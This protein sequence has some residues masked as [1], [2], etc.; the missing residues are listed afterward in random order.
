MA[1]NIIDFKTALLKGGARPN[2]FRVTLEFPTAVLGSVGIDSNTAKERSTFLVKAAQIPSSNLG[3]IEIP[4]KGRMLKVAGDR[5]FDPW[6]VTVI[7]DGDFS[8]RKLFED[9]SRQINAL[10]ENVSSLGYTSSN[11]SLAYC[12]D[13]IVTQ[14]SREG[15]GI[16]ER[17]SNTTRAVQGGVDNEIEVRS[18]KYY[19]AWPSSISAIDLNYESNNQI[20][21]FTVEFQYQY[22]D[23]VTT[24]NTTSIN[25]QAT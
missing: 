16:R 8:L 18:Y 9:W 3:V 10:S 14:L 5:T 13:M 24:S 1:K 7:N 19:D 2:L 12:K 15:N 6:S 25:Q 22:Y 23:V 21:E 17:E 11:T 20:E 4:F